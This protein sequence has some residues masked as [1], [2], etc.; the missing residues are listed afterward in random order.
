MPRWPSFLFV[1]VAVASLLALAAAACYQQSENLRL[2]G[3]CA[4]QAVAL[5]RLPGLEA[6]LA[7]LEQAA[8]ALREEVAQKTAVGR[9][10]ESKLAAEIARGRSL[11]DEIEAAATAL[12]AERERHDKELWAEKRFMPEGVREALVTL[13]DCLRQDGFTG[14]RFLDAGSIEDRTLL[15]VKM[16]QHDPISLKRTLY[17]ADSVC[18]EL[19]RKSQSLAFRFRGGYCRGS[20]G[21]L[22]FPPEGHLFGLPAVDGPMWEM[23][24]PY[25]VR[26][27]GDYPAAGAERAVAA[28]MPAGR[29][30]G[31]AAR[32]NELLEA[33]TTEVRYRLDRFHDLDD[34]RFQD[35]VFLGYDAGRKLCMS[36][37]CREMW[38]EIDRRDAAVA[39]CMTD[40]LLRDA[41]GETAIPASGYR[42]QLTG[43]SPS[44]AAEMML[45]MVLRR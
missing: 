42:I 10:L 20:D 16:L 17:V 29:R 14:I 13:H 35:V 25:L 2:R 43:T 1:L 37:E 33:A 30:A 40:G 15:G 23:R 27:E 31:W 32:V 34:G 11:S 39:V 18:F 7:G 9:V 44:Q 41:G 36:V 19:D 8:A 6:R 3:R 38:V 45:G 21:R 28:G 4:R 5:E 24:L 22:G 12:R 26:A